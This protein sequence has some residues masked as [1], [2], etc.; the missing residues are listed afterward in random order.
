[1]STEHEPRR[2]WDEF[3]EGATLGASRRDFLRAAGYVV[4]GTALAGCAPRAVDRALPYVAQP[5][6][7]TAGLPTWYASTCG[8]CP[9]ACGVLVKCRDGRPIKLEGN[10]DHPLSRG[11]LCAVGQ[12]SLLGVYDSLR[13]RGPRLDGAEATWEQ[14]DQAVAE[15]LRGPVRVLGGSGAGPT[16]REAVG[17]FVRAH[18]G[19]WITYDAVSLSAL[20]EAHAQTHGARLVPGYRFDRAAV[21]AGFGCDFLGTW[22]SPVEFTRGYAQRRVPRGNW[23]EVS[24]HWQAEAGLSLTGSNAD[25]RVA[26]APDQFG[27]V[28]EQ[29][30]WRICAWAGQPLGW[31]PAPAALPESELDDLAGRLWLAR[32][33]SLVVCGHNEL[34]CQLLVNL[35]NQR[36]G[37]YGRTLELERRSYQASGSDPLLAELQAEL[38]A[39]TVGTLIL[40]DGN[41]VADLPGDLAAL[42]ARVPLVISLA[43]HLDETSSLAHLVCP[44]H[45]W[46]ESWRDVEPRN[47]TLSL[48][49]PAI[50][51]LFDTRSAIETFERWSGGARTA[52][53]LV[54][55]R[56]EAGVLP[57]QTAER[58]FEAFWTAALAKGCAEVTPRPARTRAFALPNLP[59]A[60]PASEAMQVELYAGVAMRDGRHAGNPWLH[61]LPDPITKSTWD[62]LACLSRA[63]ADRLGLAEGDVVRVEADGVAIELPVYLLPGQAPGVVSVAL[64]YGRQAGER[65]AELGPDWLEAGPTVGPNG[66]VG[67]NAAPLITWVGDERRYLRAASV[68]PTGARREL[69]LTQTYH[70]SSVPEH[71]APE[72]GAERP[73]IQQTTLD[74]YRRDRQAGAP[75]AHDFG[76]A[77]LWPADHQYTGHHWALVVDLNACTGCAAC[78]L[79]CNVENNVPTVGRD[80]V[81]RRREL[82][83][84]RIDRYFAE[85]EDGTVDTAH[86]PMLCQHCDNAP[87]EVVCPVLATVHS[88]EGLNQQVYNRCVGTRYCANN[89]PYKVRRFNWFDYPRAEGL[90]NLVLNPEVTVR[91]RGVME[92]CSFCAQR[93]EA[94]RIAARR[95]GREL[96]DGD[97]QPACQQSCPAGAIIFGDRND[98]RSAVSRAVRDPRGYQLLVEYNLK[99]SVGYLRLVRNRPATGEREHA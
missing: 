53:E 40:L 38:E 78:V 82:H 19:R 89:C 1:M 49:Q 29:L 33:R 43:A 61:E 9:A 31:T 3:A 37:N 98:P 58:E 22:L 45:H 35:L 95:E 99:P 5:E 30:A 64:G 41:P 7:A 39:G 36:L 51:P 42:I 34:R 85:H 32:G 20:R 54:R 27:P 63:D 92:K 44:D 50:E 68:T 76:D 14:V 23:P 62:N 71:L 93:I 2:D 6:T 55:A 94:A 80:E 56:W 21:I 66:R 25:R 18:D 84:L 48:G 46:L 83:W 47:G 79:A 65:F 70:S 96:A 26:L 11:G 97:I 87:C 86:Q 67:V 91:S 88:D 24:Y 59:P 10:P 90:E 75:H 77:D 73:V 60:A 15:R 72:A 4:A 17:R 74:E 12:A 81:R 13:L 69:A 52:H 8:G 57:R 28:L 16:L